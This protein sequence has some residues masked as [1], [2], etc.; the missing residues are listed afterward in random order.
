[1]SKKVGKLKT[2]ETLEAH[3]CR[4]PIGDPRQEGFHFCGAPKTLGRPYCAHHWEMSFVPGRG[5][6][7]SSQVQAPVLV[8]RAA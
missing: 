7:Q 3:E 1:M 4:W 8:V 2:L 6:G 5:R